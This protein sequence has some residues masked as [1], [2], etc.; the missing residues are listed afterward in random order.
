VLALGCGDAPPQD[1]TPQTETVCG[2]LLGRPGPFQ[3]KP[4][5]AIFDGPPKF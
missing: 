5:A 4:R 1:G 2:V 3:K